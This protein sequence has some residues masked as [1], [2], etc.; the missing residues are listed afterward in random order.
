[1]HALLPILIPL[2]ALAVVLGLFV[3]LAA[4]IRRRGLAGG[5]ASAALASYEEAFRATAHLAH[6]EIRAQTERKAPTR[7]LTITADSSW[8]GRTVRATVVGRSGYATAVDPCE[9]PRAGRGD[10]GMGA[11]RCPCR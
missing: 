9:G 4:R 3:R 2:G 7:R 6:Y 8:T 1:M 5:A 11:D 10:G